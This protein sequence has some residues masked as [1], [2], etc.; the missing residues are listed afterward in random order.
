MSDEQHKSQDEI[1]KAI[2]FVKE[3]LDAGE[4]PDQIIRELEQEGW[5]H[6]DVQSLVTAV[7][8]QRRQA[9]SA[10]ERF[11]NMKPIGSAPSMFTLNGFGVG[12]YGSRD[13]DPETGTYVK[14]HCVCAIFVPLFCLGAYRVLKDPG[15]NG[16]YFIGKEPLS[17]LARFWNWFLVLGIASAIG[18]GAWQSHKSSPEYI[19][20]K[21]L[22]EA[23][24]LVEAGQLPRAARL[25]EEVA[26]G[27]TSHSSAG[28]ESLKEL[29]TSDT[30][31]QAAVGDQTQVLGSA[32]RT[33]KIKG[34]LEVAYD[35][36]EP[37]IVEIAGSNPDAAMHAWTTV[38]DLK[39]DPALEL[40][41]KL[42]AEQFSELEPDDTYQLFET[43]FSGIRDAKLVAGVAGSG[44]QSVSSLLQTDAESAARLL[45]LVRDNSPAEMFASKLQALVTEQ[46]VDLNAEQARILLEAAWN[47]TSP[48]NHDW[49]VKV[50]VDWID[51]HEAVPATSSLDVLT[52]FKSHSDPD[53]HRLRE[54]R[55]LLL[56]TVVTESP[57]NLE[58]RVELADLLN[59]EG[60]MD[61]VYDLLIGFRDQVG[62][63][64]GARLLG[65]ALAARGEFDASYELLEPY[66]ERQ[67]SAL[68]AAEKKLDDAL[69]RAQSRAIS[70]LETGSAAGFRYELYRS[71]TEA[72]KE[73]LVNEF[74]INAIQNDGAVA[75][76]R[77]EMASQSDIVSVALDLGIVTLRRAQ[78]MQDPSQRQAE[79]EKAEKTFLAV[80]GAAG[81][82]DR[83]RLYLGQVYY[84]LGK[85]EEGHAIFDELLE[86][87]NRSHEILMAVSSVLYE[88]GVVGEVRSL[89]EEAYESATND[90]QR[91]EAAQMRSLSSIDTEDRVEW[92]NKSDVTQLGVKAELAT[93]RGY[94]A[95]EDGDDEAATGHY[96][97]AIAIYEQ[98]PESAAVFN[99]GA[100]VFLALY[101]ATG[102]REA[103]Q[104]GTQWLEESVKLDPSEAIGLSNLASNLMRLGLITLAGEN[105]DLRDLEMSG[106]PRA[107]NAFATDAEQLKK[108]RQKLLADEDVSDAIKHFEKVIVLS[109]KRLS[110]YGFLMS[111][112]SF[113]HNA[114]GLQQVSDQFM[115]AQPDMQEM[116]NETMS[117]YLAPEGPEDIERW[118][119]LLTESKQR[120][121]DYRGAG[122]PVAYALAVNNLVN[123]SVRAIGRDA[124][125]DHDALV[126][127]AE[128]VFKASPSVST[129]GCLIRAC[130]FRA[131]AQLVEQSPEFAELS[132]QCVRSIGRNYLIAAAM[133]LEGDAGEKVRTH[134]DVQRAVDLIAESAAK[135]PDMVSE[136]DWAMLHAAGHAAAENAGEFIATDRFL[137]YQRFTGMLMSPVN[138]AG[139]MNAY[140]A[141][142]AGS[143]GE[144]SAA[145]LKRLTEL[146]LPIPSTILEQR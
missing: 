30:F 137:K 124:E 11:P 117:T 17:G 55:R 77:I 84:W 138:V 126:E 82:S 62:T 142:Q 102:E 28:R 64:E 35:L 88:I 27:M 20:E 51:Q 139:A 80:Q 120:V 90:E 26:T 33:H 111:V 37:I 29:L 49:V 103:L 109:P 125:H 73:E 140:W 95:A 9:E 141:E 44:L 75:E 97:K 144:E 130:L 101:S 94:L 87:Q 132:T 10:E 70:S 71:S 108:L 21:K 8:D 63:G 66:V 118:T 41:Q 4:S 114:D 22:R 56:E 79:L 85:Q 65:Q 96:R 122:Q 45:T 83:Y 24:E 121:E 86:S 135:F 134:P 59:S 99:N 146:G 5:P 14:T 58:Y 100:L 131:S 106:D 78:G 60:E 57:G 31:S 19:A 116:I 15:G 34:G 143:E 36:S 40:F 42:E 129:Y 68:H 16:W 6:D 76:A 69:E 128:S 2:E 25:Y 92:L 112:H 61:R 43:A 50:G 3:E 13:H 91:H 98:M 107:L 23:E 39:P 81:D 74:I 12:V 127:L 47:L 119:T 133:T 32:A 72:R 115:A 145:M 48:E 123:H 89:T 110:A 1:A 136:W 38:A 67:L 53:A 18:L 105:V 104:S 54:R 113:T 46:V 52:V 93:A 7:V